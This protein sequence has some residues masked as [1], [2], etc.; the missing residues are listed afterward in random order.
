METSEIYTKALVI[1]VI[2]MAIGFCINK[3][4]AW[5]RDE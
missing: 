1:L 2:A 4:G 3:I 5:I